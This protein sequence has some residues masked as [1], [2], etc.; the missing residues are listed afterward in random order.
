MAASPRRRNAGVVGV[1]AAL[2]PL[3]LLLL[4]GASAPIIAA[5][6][7][8]AAAQP[9]PNGTVAQLWGWWT[10]GGDGALPAGANDAFRCL[11]DAF[12]GGPR[13]K[14]VYSQ[15]G[16]DGI[17]E[18]VFDCIG[19]GEKYYVEFG[20]ESCDECTTRYLR[21]EKGWR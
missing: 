20:T 16:E 8:A 10:R 4:V 15:V 13:D 5:D 19:Q 18:A 7:D 14:K 12:S 11:A 9:P 17:L 2:P 6:A 3:L 21:D 1:M